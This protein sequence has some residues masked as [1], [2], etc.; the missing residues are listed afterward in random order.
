M[1][2]DTVTLVS[3]HCHKGGLARGEEEPAARVDKAAAPEGQ[4]EWGQGRKGRA[5]EKPQGCRPR[6]PA[7]DRSGEAFTFMSPE[8]R[9]AGQQHLLHGDIRQ[10]V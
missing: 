7:S 10:W 4:G 3:P 6:L 1:K 8:S 9:Q 2:T 5:V